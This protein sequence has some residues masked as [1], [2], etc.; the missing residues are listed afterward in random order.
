MRPGTYPDRLLERFLL[1]AGFAKLFLIAAFFASFA[2]VDFDHAVAD[3]MDRCTGI[4]LVSKIKSEDPETYAAMVKEASATANARSIFW[5]IEKDGQETSWLFGTMH[6]ADPEIAVLPKPVQSALNRADNVVIETTD[7]LDPGASAKAMAGLGHLTML[8]NEQALSQLVQEDLRD[9]LESA[10]QARGIPMQ[11]GDR[12]QPWLVATTVSLPVCEM[13]RKRM[14]AKVLDQVIAE[15]AANANKKVFGL[16]T[17]AEQFEAIASLPQAF[18]LAALEQTLRS[19][20]KALDMIETLKRL[21]LESRTGMILPLMKTVTPESFSG[22]D[23]ARFQQA[24][25]DTRNETMLSRMI[26]ILESGSS[27]VAVGALHLPGETGIVSLLRSK[28]Y[29]L[30]AM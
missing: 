20:T 1:A 18:H 6:M 7:I 9:E 28:G 12:L 22:S 14:G 24:L 11:L 21:Y 23:S 13:L 15:E 10:L 16:E 17:M 8:G 2:H 4:N 3:E 30:T 5:K 29:T 26:P 27:L 19:N 25:I